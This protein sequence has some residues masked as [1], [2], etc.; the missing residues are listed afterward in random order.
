MIPSSNR[1]VSSDFWSVSGTGKALS[2]VCKDSS[3]LH[4][5]WK[6][7]IAAMLEVPMIFLRDKIPVTMKKE[8][9]LGVCT[10]CP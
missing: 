6:Q 10:A 7:P 5:Q 3:S 8:D 9:A 4:M 1:T 2:L